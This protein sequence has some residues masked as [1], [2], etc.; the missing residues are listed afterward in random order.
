M[1]FKKKNV[2]I[3]FDISGFMFSLVNGINSIVVVFIRSVVVREVVMTVLGI[4]GIID[5]VRNGR[6]L[7]K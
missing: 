3:V 1:V 2:V 7:E 4:F 5:Y 6:S